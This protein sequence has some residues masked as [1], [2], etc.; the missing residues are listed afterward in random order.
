MVLL[1]GVRSPCGAALGTALLILLPEWLRFL[2]VTYLAVYGGAVILLMVFMPEG[3]WGFLETLRQRLW[4]PAVLPFGRVVPLPLTTQAAR[5]D[6]STILEV[7]QLSKHFGG[8]KAVD[9]VELSVRRNTVHALVG[10]NGSGKT[11]LLN[12]LSGI[13]KPTTGGL[14]F[15]GQAVTCL[16]PHE[17]AGRGIGR[18]FQNVRLFTAMSVLENIIVGAERPGNEAAVGLNTVEKSELVQLLKRLKGHGLT[19]LVIDHDMN[20][21][22]QVADRITVLNFGRRIADGPPAEVLRNPEVMAA[23]LGSVKTHG[24]P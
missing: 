8:L 1:G 3:I 18:T 23:Y 24:A 9:E 12:V 5:E 2:K 17:R 6:G 14:F 19:I 7:N 10:P 4:P 20:L 21:V 13:Y 16:L 11:T 22:D 15:D